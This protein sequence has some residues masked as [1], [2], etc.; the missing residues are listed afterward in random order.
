M[1]TNWLEFAQKLAANARAGLAE[2]R[3]RLEKILAEQK[4]QQKPQAPARPQ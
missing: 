4:D 2:E 1:D 3:Q